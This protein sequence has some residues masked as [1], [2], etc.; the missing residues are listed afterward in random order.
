MGLRI[1]LFRS[2]VSDPYSRPETGDSF[3][4]LSGLFD[5]VTLGELSAISSEGRKSNT[6]PSGSN[7]CRIPVGQAGR[8]VRGNSPGRK[9]LGS[10]LPFFGCRYHGNTQFVPASGKSQEV[11][12]V[13]VT[14]CMGDCCTSF[15]VGSSNSIGLVEAGQSVCPALFGPKLKLIP[16]NEITGKLKS[17]QDSDS[18]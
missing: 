9:I 5:T 17:S 14:I 12:A 4:L 10:C 16:V 18:P 15:R 13:A 11:P 7:S 3:G 1:A 6:R 2:V 8:L